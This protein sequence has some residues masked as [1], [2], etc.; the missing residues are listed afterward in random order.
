MLLSEGYIHRVICSKTCLLHP[1][2]FCTQE[3]PFTMVN[4]SA[5]LNVGSMRNHPIHWWNFFQP[6]YKLLT[7][8]RLRKTGNP[9]LD[10]QIS[11]KK[12]HSGNG[13]LMIPANVMLDKR[14]SLSV[15][16]KDSLCGMSCSDDIVVHYAWILR[17][18][19]D[20]DFILMDYNIRTDRDS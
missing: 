8:F 4:R 5:T 10:F 17:D 12:K 3:I 9:L 7:Y 6:K 20:P 16:V 11:R 15:L 1:A 14:T 13:N 19:V 2:L 18:A